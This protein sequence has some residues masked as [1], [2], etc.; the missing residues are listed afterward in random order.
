VLGVRVAFLPIDKKVR[1]NHRSY[2]LQPNSRIY[3]LSPC[4][5]GP[6]IFVADRI[7]TP[8]ST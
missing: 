8:H 6:M 5:A 1:V 7:S 3:W 2:L 4:K